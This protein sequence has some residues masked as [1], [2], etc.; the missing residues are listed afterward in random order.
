[1]GDEAAEAKAEAE[2]E[3]GGEVSA[4]DEEAAAT[5]REDGGGTAGAGG[6]CRRWAGDAVFGRGRGGRRGGALLGAERGVGSWDGAGHRAD[7]GAGRGSAGVVERGRRLC[8]SRKVQFSY[9]LDRVKFQL[10]WLSGSIGLLVRDRLGHYFGGLCYGLDDRASV[11]GRE[12][13]RLRGA[14]GS[15][16][17]GRDCGSFGLGFAVDIW[18]RE[19]TTRR[20]RSRHTRDAGSDGDLG[21]RAKRGLCLLSLELK[22]GMALRLALRCD[23][24]SLGRSIFSSWQSLR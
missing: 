18:G 12:A 16:A 3:V 21:L 14:F 24:V 22:L 17:C 19:V 20:Q 8:S 9:D 1:V 13:V 5:G 15:L 10:G 11:G 6:W 4:G 23:L 7:G 2:A